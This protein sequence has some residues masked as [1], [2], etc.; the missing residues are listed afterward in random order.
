MKTLA[1][2][3]VFAL[4]LAT[5]VPATTGAQTSAYDYIVRGE[6]FLG[7]GLADDAVREFTQALKL[8]PQNTRAHFGLGQG[9]EL[10]SGIQGVL[11]YRLECMT[12]PAY[13]RAYG[14]PPLTDRGYQDI[15]QALASYGRALSPGQQV[16]GAYYRQGMLYFASGRADDA[17]RAL[18]QAVAAEPSNVAARVLLAYQYLEDGQASMASAQLDRARTAGGDPGN[19]LILAA[20]GVVEFR[21]GRFEAADQYFSQALARYDAP[22]YIEKFLGDARSALGRQAEALDA[23]RRAAYKDRT[24]TLTRDRLGNAYRLSGEAQAAMDAYTEASTANPNLLRAKFGLACAMLESG[25]AAAAGPV[26]ADILTSLPEYGSDNALVL[27][28]I[29]EWRLGDPSR[30]LATLQ[31]ALGLNPGNRVG[32]VYVSRLEAELRARGTFPTGVT[33]R[34]V[35]VAPIPDKPFS[36]VLINGGVQHTN[37]TQV[38][39]AVYSP[40]PNVSFSNDGVTWSPWYSKPGEYCEFSWNLTP[41]DGVKQ[42]QVKFRDYWGFVTRGESGTITLDS[43]PA[44]VSIGVSDAPGANPYFRDRVRV[45][46]S[47][48]DPSGIAGFWLSFDGAEWRWFDWYSHDFV[49]ALPSTGASRIFLS[50]VDGAGNHASAEA[51]IPPAA[52]LDTVPPEGGIAVAGGTAAINSPYV[53][54]ALWARDNVPGQLEMSFSTDGRTYGPW[55]AFAA[56]KYIQLPPGDDT[57]N[58]YVRFRDAA[59][60]VSQ[61][62]VASIVLDTRAPRIYNVQVTAV[63]TTSAAVS[64]STDEL[65]DSAVEFWATGSPDRVSGTDVTGVHTISLAG[66]RPGTTYGFRVI[67]RDAA[68]NVARSEDM[69]FRTLSPDTRP[70]SVSLRI[71]GGARYANSRILQLEVYAQDDQPGPL[72]MTIRDDGT[73]FGYWRPHSVNTT[74]QLTGAEG[75]RTVYVRVRDQAGNET[76]AEASIVLDVTPPQIS[77][78]EAKTV[79]PDS[80]TITWW[81]NEF[82]DSWVLYGPLA[83]TRTSGWG[84][85]ELSHSVTITGLNPNTVYF[86]KVRS[87]DDA[88]N[89]AESA[90]STFRTQQPRDTTPP[91]GS[92][93]INDSARYTRSTLVSLTLSASDDSGGRIEMRL[94]EDVGNWTAWQTLASKTNFRLTPG[95]GTR[96]I[97]AE[98]RD[99]SANV[100]RTYSASI[101]LDTRAPRITNVRTSDVTRNS[102]TITWNT[103]EPATSTVE[104]GLSGA[105]MRDTA[106]EKS[107]TSAEAA[108]GPGDVGAKVI[109][110]P[111]L[112]PSQLTTNHSV[113]LT[114]L[115]SDT[116]YYYQVVSRDAAG[117]VAVLSGFSF[118][119]AGAPP[120]PPPPPA[121]PPSTPPEPP[122]SPPPPPPPGPPVKVNWALSSNGGSATASSYAAARP[123]S[124]ARP[125]AYAIDGNRQTYWEAG[126]PGSSPNQWIE[127]RFAK[128]QTIGFI[129]TVSDIGHY[130]VEMTVQYDRDGQWVDLVDT[131]S[132]L[133]QNKY[134]KTSGSTFMYEIPFTAVTTS[135]IRIIVHRVS[136]PRVAVQFSEIEV[137]TSSE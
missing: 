121:K 63:G 110:V 112:P 5:L 53:T 75:K 88:G 12:E 111:E 99:P 58:V 85:R 109:I 70:P 52:P 89:T 104:Y 82:A 74:W 87:T 76:Q 56:T 123:G 16:V 51:A 3:V 23:Y 21:A 118:T 29:S 90:V 15:D 97:Y 13:V 45:T 59:G 98:F 81:T 4:V 135:G 50:V 36:G 35:T 107:V 8:E 34:S 100:S 46:L 137:Y 96:T 31:S 42:V 120:P 117:N 37:S 62:Y 102:A 25:R 128:P 43:T 91:T 28:A 71:N 126:S 18:E 6:R 69:S 101:V 92:I 86:F 124:Q 67:S 106:G 136:N 129:R 41:G 105:L 14:F 11:T 20:M 19:P 64:W 95:D 77:W 94:R 17:R 47:A 57:K 122:V 9:Y 116:T 130:A 33:T 66:L 30:A 2:L 10:R 60:N 68:G 32:Q 40:I 132:R 49:V 83:P 127:I 103:D 1:R 26:F 125:A 72:E 114:R 44:S 48:T 80:A 133:D 131:K 54:A 134:K 22:A 38:R 61:A 108:T 113:T 78:V 93:R 7:Q 24:L 39:V 115:N 55:E 79:G 27:R 84:D 73:P 119:T 65:A